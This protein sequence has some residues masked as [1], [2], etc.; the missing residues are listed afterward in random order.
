MKIP[1]QPLDIFVSWSKYLLTCWE[2]LIVE[3][4]FQGV[5]IS[6]EHKTAS[7]FKMAAKQAMKENLQCTSKYGHLRISQNICHVRMTDIDGFLTIYGHSDNLLNNKK[8]ISIL[9]I[10]MK[11]LCQYFTVNYDKQSI[12]LIPLLSDLPW[13][14]RSRREIFNQQERLL[15][16]NSLRAICAFERW[17]PTG[18]PS[19]VSVVG[20]AFIMAVS[21]YQICKTKAE[22]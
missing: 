3:S 11:R 13:E 12:S 9:F 1:S 10:L 15:P 16:K 6:G 20:C 7:L 14:I 8:T 17:W 5:K 19:S 4:F 21:V 2:H 18:L 22:I